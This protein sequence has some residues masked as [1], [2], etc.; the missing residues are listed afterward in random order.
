MIFNPFRAH[1]RLHRFRDTYPI[2]KTQEKIDTCPLTL[3][4]LLASF[5]RLFGDLQMLHTF[6]PLKRQ[7]LQP[8]QMINTKCTT[9]VFEAFSLLDEKW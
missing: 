3:L 8:Q 2:W 1:S 6:A 5:C 9:L 7:K 4:L